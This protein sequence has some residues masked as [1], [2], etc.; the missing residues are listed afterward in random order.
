MLING[1]NQLANNNNNDI[2]LLLLLLLLLSLK[3]RWDDI[4]DIVTREEGKMYI[5]VHDVQ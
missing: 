1:L 2:L 4:K 3:A 5:L